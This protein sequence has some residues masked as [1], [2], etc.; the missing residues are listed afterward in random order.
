MHRLR[1]VSASIEVVLIPSDG[2]CSQTTQ[3]LVQS[4]L[5][6]GIRENLTAPAGNL[7]PVPLTMAF[8]F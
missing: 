5:V 3:Y 1:P 2:Y 6:L 7:P 8:L 4:N